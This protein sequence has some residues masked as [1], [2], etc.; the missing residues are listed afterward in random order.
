[1]SL[2]T[3]IS[4]SGFLLLETVIACAIMSMMVLFIAHYHWH[5]QIQNIQVSNQINL[6]LDVYTF[7]EKKQYKHEPSGH[8]EGKS[9][10]IS[11]QK[12]PAIKNDSVSMRPMQVELRYTVAGREHIF[13]LV[14]VA[15]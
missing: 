9:G 8:N 5:M 13:K 4:R 15:L 11:W 14:S 1:M 2:S 6:L 3:I 12:L 10:T 7:F